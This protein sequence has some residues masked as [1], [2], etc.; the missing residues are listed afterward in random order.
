MAEHMSLDTDIPIK[1]D[2]DDSG[3]SSP[4]G[5]GEG[6]PSGNPQ[7]SQQPRRK[8]GRKPVSRED[9]NPSGCLF[10]SLLSPD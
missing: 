6:E 1:V 3:G 9:P 8:G 2:S 5:E 4:E 10:L 7:E